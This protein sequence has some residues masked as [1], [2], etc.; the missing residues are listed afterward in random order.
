MKSTLVFKLPPAGKCLIICL[1]GVL[2]ACSPPPNKSDDW[3]SL[4]NGKNLDGWKKWKG[5][6]IT[7][8]KVEDGVL[9]LAEKGGGHIL[10]ENE[11]GDFELE[12]E[13]KISEKGNSGIQFHVKES[14]DY[15]C[16]F[17]VGP[18]IQILDDSKHPDNAKGH[19]LDNHKSGALYDLLPPTDLTA[20][21]P[22]GQWNQARI[23]VNKGR[24]ESWLN[25]KKV[26]D[27]PLRGPEWE[28]MI[29]NSKFAEHPDFG[30]F[31]RGS[32]VLQD[33]N[34]QVWFRNIRVREL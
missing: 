4:F 20:V 8:W 5:G 23:V 11:Y 26:L 19:A 16:P 32:I 10:T 12:L 6:P 15:C 18:E 33:H 1:L 27:F 24:G 28:R 7:G 3:K 21:K 29:A 2:C 30:K 22:A 14:D 25:G 13:W 31:D 17:V 34:N 9:F